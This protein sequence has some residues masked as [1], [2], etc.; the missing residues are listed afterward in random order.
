MPSFG[1]NGAIFATALVVYFGVFILPDNLFLMAPG[2]EA[3]LTSSIL[4]ANDTNQPII[5]LINETATTIAPEVTMDEVSRTVDDIMIIASIGLLM[6]A[7]L[8]IGARFV[9]AISKCTSYSIQ[10]PTV[11]YHV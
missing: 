10:E 9:L 7:A 1:N 8:G 6:A 3:S 2:I 11:A 5:A 4:Y